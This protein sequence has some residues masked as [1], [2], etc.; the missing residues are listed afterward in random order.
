MARG[1]RAWPV[2]DCSLRSPRV[3]LR[4]WDTRCFFLAILPCGLIGDF[5]HALGV[6]QERF[7]FAGIALGGDFLSVE[8]EAD[9]AG[10]ADSGD[11][12]AGGAEGG[13][14]GGDEGFVSDGLAV[15][16]DGDPGSF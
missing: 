5:A 16:S 4:L 11:E 14:G 2:R 6:E 13:G 1:R 10:V 3:N 8:Q 9:A 12:F 15:G 7:D